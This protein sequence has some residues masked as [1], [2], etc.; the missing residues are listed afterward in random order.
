MMVG[1]DV[2]RHRMTT[3]GIYVVFILEFF[4]LFIFEEYI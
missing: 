3:S 1:K 4:V 2:A